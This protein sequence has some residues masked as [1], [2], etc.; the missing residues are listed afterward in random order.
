MYAHEKQIRDDGLTGDEKRAYRQNHTRQFVETYWR[1]CRSQCHR[2]ELLSK[3]PLAK[4]SNNAQER[5]SGLE[6][7][8]DNPA[9]AMDTNH[10]ERTR[11]P[12]PLGKRNWLFTSS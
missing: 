7:F 12:V 4:A 1:W 9:V 8:L 11:R 2:P 6:L 5:R 3:S 10:V